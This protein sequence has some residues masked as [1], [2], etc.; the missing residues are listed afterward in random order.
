M[1]NKFPPRIFVKREHEDKMTWLIA[2]DVPD[3]FVA[4][5]GKIKIGVY[6]LD[7]V[8]T[9]TGVVKRES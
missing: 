5:G 2:D 1:T 9:L 7:H 8:E 6:K 4:I 3:T